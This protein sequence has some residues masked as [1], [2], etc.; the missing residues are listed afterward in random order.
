MCHVDV[1][2]LTVKCATLRISHHFNVRVIAVRKLHAGIIAVIA[3]D[4]LEVDATYQL[5]VF[6]LCD[7][8]SNMTVQFNEPMKLNP[9]LHLIRIIR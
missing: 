7:A 2:P 9:K 4:F 1:R 5:S 3:R 8:K 6:L